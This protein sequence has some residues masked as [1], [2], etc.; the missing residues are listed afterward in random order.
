MA[1][2]SVG[3][4]RRR[5]LLM[6][7]AVLAVYTAVSPQQAGAVTSPLSRARLPKVATIAVQMPSSSLSKSDDSGPLDPP[8]CLSYAP[9]PGGPV[10]LAIPPC[11]CGQ[12]KPA[13]IGEVPSDAGVDL[14]GSLSGGTH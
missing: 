13:H 14:S 12:I 1:T 11:V 9:S 3:D 7:S 2:Y 10:C 8:K 4:R 5:H 6:M